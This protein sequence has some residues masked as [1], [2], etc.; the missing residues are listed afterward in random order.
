MNLTE[1]REAVIAQ[2]SCPLCN[3]ALGARCWLVGTRAEGSDLQ[4]GYVHDDRS[5]VYQEFREQ[6]AEH[7]IEQTARELPVDHHERPGLIRAAELLRYD[8]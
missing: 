2:T 7:A 4:V 6:W 1:Y 3:A 5:L 8:G